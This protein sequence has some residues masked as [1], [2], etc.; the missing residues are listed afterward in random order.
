SN[1]PWESL[2]LATGHGTKL[3]RFVLVDHISDDRI[4]GEARAWYS[5]GEM[6]VYKMPMSIDILTL[7][8]SRN[9]RRHS[10]WTTGFLH[11][12][13]RSLKFQK[14]SKLDTPLRE[15]W[16]K[17][18]REDHDQISREEWLGA[19]QNDYMFDDLVKHVEVRLP[20]VSE[21]GR[22]QDVMK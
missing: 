14:K 15:S 12:R 18:W 4:C 20:D 21:I 5:L 7:G 16:Q 3:H 6:A 19:M 17:I 1:Y 10:A 9:G 22:I 13:N 8:A 2:S 11:P